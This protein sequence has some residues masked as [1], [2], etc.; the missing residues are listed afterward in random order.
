VTHRVAGAHTPPRRRRH[1]HLG[2]K[3]ARALLGEV[4]LAQS[5]GIVMYRLTTTIFALWCA[6]LL[7]V[8]K[9]V[10]LDPGRTIV[11]FHHT[12]WTGR[13]G[14]PTGVWGMAQSSDGYLWLGTAFGLYRFDGV[15]FERFEPREGALAHVN[16]TSVAA[17][18]EGDVWV[19]YQNGGVSRI[20]NGRVVNFE[21]GA[22]L[23]IGAVNAILRSDNAIW[24]ATT[25]GLS[26]FDGSAWRTVDER[27]N[28]PTRHVV[29]IAVARDGALWAVGLSGIA[30]LPAGEQQFRIWSQDIGGKRLARAPDG[31]LWLCNITKKSA[32]LLPEQGGNVLSP[33]SSSHAA[34]IDGDGTL[35]MADRATGLVR[36]KLNAVPQPLSSTAPLD[37]FSSRDG[38]SSDVVVSLLHDR[39]GN[40][41]AGSSLGLDRFR[42]ANIVPETAISQTSSFGY[43]AARKRDGTLLFADT[44]AVY[45]VRAGNSAETLAPAPRARFIREDREGALWI[46]TSELMRLQNG[47]FERVAPPPLGAHPVVWGMAEDREGAIWTAA[48]RHNV[49]RRIK[50]TWQQVAPG[51]L[52]PEAPFLMQTDDR[53]GIWLSYKQLVL[54]NGNDV[55]A[56]DSPDIGPLAV[57]YPTANSVLLGGERGLARFD[58]TSFKRLTDDRLPPST[59][60]S[61][62]VQTSDGETWLNTKH[63]IVRVATGELDKAFADPRYAPPY[64]LFDFRDGLMGT[65]QQDT[66][67]NTAL[68]GPDSRLWF[69]TGNGVV[70]I[71]PENLHRNLHPPPVLITSLVADGKRVDPAA[72]L[73]LAAG[74]TRLQIDYTALSLTA[75]E[76]V[77]FRYK[78]EGEDPGWIDPGGRRQ[79]FYTNLDPGDYRFR[80]IAANNDGIWN[81][82]GAT[83]TF[84]IPP[85]FLQ[86]KWFVFLCLLAGAAA[87]WLLYSL[88]LRQMTARLRGRLEERLA[89]RERIARELHDTL[90]Q[91]FQ[92]LMLRF[93]AVAERIPADHPAR[94][95]MNE[96]LD[97]GDDVL[98]EGRDSVRNLRVGR[99]GDLAQALARVAA[100]AARDPAVQFSIVEEGTPANLHPVVHDEVVKIGTEA[101]LNAFA[102]AKS[103]TIEVGIVYQPRRFS[104]RVRDDGIGIDADLLEKG[105]EGHFGFTGMRERAQKISGELTVLSRPGAGTEIDLTVPAGVAF[106]KDRKRFIWSASPPASE[107]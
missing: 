36:T 76:H 22:G 2:G 12:A 61:G 57:I 48:W 30:Y 31:R 46:V 93:Q 53:R 94:R 10:A 18:P 90:L 34:I 105:R 39:E 58:G 73:T 47:R 85:T 50:D 78:L 37:A 99:D 88:R 29:S 54:V 4:V 5:A 104:L 79:A 87:L 103:K 102:H 38:L 41:W 64:D 74:V 82:T 55:R 62:I 89:E 91:G 9:A 77:R 17:M 56:F 95:F 11:Q 100:D 25:E 13:D 6:G 49:Y 69:L 80:V 27:W 71:D 63:G 101:I 3:A 21:V 92:G 52:P 20:R 14:A 32:V 96:A 66:F 19:G 26:R 40:V 8:G 97:R 7:L 35:W 33:V 15:R 67:Q 23:V 42:P 84:S 45:V 83:L 65:A 70:W 68:A 59:L 98:T 24:V 44:D 72:G 81:N 107:I 43:T 106:R 75:A 60:T 16:V 51:R 86:T 1:T 28:F